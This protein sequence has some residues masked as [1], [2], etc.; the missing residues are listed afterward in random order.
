MKRSVAKRFGIRGATK[1]VVVAFLLTGILSSVAPLASVSA[2][3]ICKRACCAAMAAH[4]A[5]SCAD[6]SCHASLKRSRRHA[7]HRSAA[8]YS[9]KLCGPRK[10]EIESKT[11]PPL[12]ER[13]ATDPAQ[14]A[15]TFG[16]PCPPECSGTVSNSGSQRNSAAISSSAD[17]CHVAIHQISLA[18]THPRLSEASCR[19]CAPRG[20]PLSLS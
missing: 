9:D 15:A 7:N 17:A 3:T 19:D 13:A 6:G 8:N 16:S 10:F 1:L 20:P 18:S 2:G 12:N 5:G 14:V 4:S 11:R